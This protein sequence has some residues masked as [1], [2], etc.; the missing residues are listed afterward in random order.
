M[1]PVA[2]GVSADSGQPNNKMIGKSRTSRSDWKGVDTTRVGFPLC[3]WFRSRGRE[4]VRT[5]PSMGKQ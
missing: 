1:R 4:S 3:D 2:D 5:P